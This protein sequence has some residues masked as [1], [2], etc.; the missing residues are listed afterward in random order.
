MTPQIGGV[1]E[2]V[3]RAAL[4]RAIYDDVDPEREVAVSERISVAVS[5][6][7][8]VPVALMLALRGSALNAKDAHRALEEEPVVRVCM[9]KLMN[10]A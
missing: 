8:V 10:A 9:K 6:D 5:K 2:E 1:S 4:H 3:A 7:K